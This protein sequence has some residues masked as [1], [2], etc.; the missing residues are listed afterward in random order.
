MKFNTLCVWYIHH[1]LPILFDHINMVQIISYRFCF[2][3]PNKSFISLSKKRIFI[4][5]KLKSSISIKGPLFLMG[6]HFSKSR[7]FDKKLT[8]LLLKELMVG[9]MKLIFGQRTL[10]YITWKCHMPKLVVHVFII[11]YHY[12]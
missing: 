1:H 3:A 8:M 6:F 4:F 11:L 10:R 9:I 5:S 7:I 2:D 12:N